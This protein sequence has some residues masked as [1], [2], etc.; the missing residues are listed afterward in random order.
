VYVGTIVEQSL[1]T[2]TVLDLVDIINTVTVDVPHAVD[3]QPARWTLT[4]FRTDQPD[5]VAEQLAND[6]RPGP[7]YVDFHNDVE[8][9][10]VFRHLVFRYNVGDTD[11]LHAARAYARSVGVPESQLDWT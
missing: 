3:G 4:E 7:W 10:V 1:T 11:G 2:R 8:V 9:F 5:I 6:L